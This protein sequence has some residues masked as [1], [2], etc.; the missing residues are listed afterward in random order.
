M[1]MIVVIAS[2]AQ[3]GAAIQS[4]PAVGLD[5]FPR[6]KAGVAMTNKG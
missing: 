6:P 3:R 5:C 1:N 2:L 4:R